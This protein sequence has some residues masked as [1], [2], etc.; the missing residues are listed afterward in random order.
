MIPTG[1]GGTTKRGIYR[2]KANDN[3]PNPTLYFVAYVAG[4]IT[5]TYTDVAD[6]SAL[7]AFPGSVADPA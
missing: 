5:T 7:V 3:A 4:N 6:D 2:T 1:A